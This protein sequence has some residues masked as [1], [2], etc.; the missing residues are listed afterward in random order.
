MSLR[1]RLEDGRLTSWELA[2]LLSDRRL[3]DGWLVEWLD[4]QERARLRWL[5]WLVQQGRLER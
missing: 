2:R 1:E 4:A 3:R 5:R